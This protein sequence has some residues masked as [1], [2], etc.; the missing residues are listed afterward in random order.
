MYAALRRVTNE[1]SFPGCFMRLGLFS[2]FPSLSP[3]LS[4]YRSVLFLRAERSPVSANY[5]H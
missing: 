2:L 4:G 3:S 1:A 5:N